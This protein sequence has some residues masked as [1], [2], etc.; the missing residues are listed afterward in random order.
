MIPLDNRHAIGSFYGDLAAIDMEKVRVGLES[1]GDEVGAGVVRYQVAGTEININPTTLQCGPKFVGGHVAEPTG[2]METRCFVNNVGYWYPVNGE[3]ITI[4]RV[5]KRDIGI[6][7]RE[8]ETMWWTP[9]L[10][11]KLTMSANLAQLLDNLVVDAFAGGLADHVNQCLHA[12]VAKTSVH[13]AKLRFCEEALR[14]GGPGNESVTPVS[15]DSGFL[16]RCLMKD[17]VRKVIK[18]ETESIHFFEGKQQMQ[19]KWQKVNFTGDPF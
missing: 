2:G 5:V 18:N 3:D 19:V 13:G 6:V 4:N 1:P 11:T 8:P 7:Q 10:L 12:W 15:L 9:E 17:N 14:V 16:P